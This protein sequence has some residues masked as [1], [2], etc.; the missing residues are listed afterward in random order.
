MTK[1]EVY[2]LIGGTIGLIAGFVAAKVYQI[3]AM[4]YADIGIQLAGVTSW[5]GTPIWM[6]VNANPGMT[7]F[8]G[9]SIFTSLGLYFAHILIKSGESYITENTVE[10]DEARE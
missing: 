4:L 9:L 10:I 7:T 2:Y 3:W 8:L 5:E 1:T 6:S